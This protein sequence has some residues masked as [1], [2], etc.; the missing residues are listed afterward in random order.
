MPRIPSAP[1]TCPLCERECGPSE[2]S[3]HHV[4][5]KSQGGRQVEIVC[6]ECHRQVHALF[7]V[8]ELARQFPTL[9]ALREDAAM[10]TWIGWI[11]RRRPH[12]S[13]RRSGV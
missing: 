8:K 10:Q 13:P 7:T 9:E 4:L 1:F 6:V 5:P 3:R 2:A 11:R 12:G